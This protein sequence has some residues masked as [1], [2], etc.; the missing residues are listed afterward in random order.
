MISECTDPGARISAVEAAAEGV[1][2]LEEEE[3]NPR[4]RA[5]VFVAGAAA[6]VVCEEHIQGQPACLATNV[7]VWDADDG[8]VG[9]GPVGGGGGGG[10]G[11]GWRIAHHQVGALIYHGLRIARE[12]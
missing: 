1:A 9:G 8:L 12:G 7:F 3:E 6:W 10:G 5:Q 4:G 11:G 2:L